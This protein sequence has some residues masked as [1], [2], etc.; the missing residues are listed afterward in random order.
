VSNIPR[1]WIALLLIVSV[2]MLAISRS[3]LWLG[4]LAVVLVVGAY[5]LVRRRKPNFFVQVG[6]D[7]LVINALTRRSIGY[8][9]IAAVDFY[10]YK[11]GELVRAIQNFAILINS[12][13]GGEGRK[14]PP[15]GEVDTSVVELRFAKLMWMRILFPPFVLPRRHLLLRVEDA[16]SLR[17][18]INRKLSPRHPD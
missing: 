4:S 14:V 1:Y 12:F 11:E 2:A 15:A 3:P 16:D 7:D 13:F 5:G 17:S 18:E 10:R 8:R 6:E 9:D